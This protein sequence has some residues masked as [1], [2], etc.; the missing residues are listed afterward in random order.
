MDNLVKERLERMA[1][2]ARKIYTVN[3][4]DCD[5]VEVAELNRLA[6]LIS[7]DTGWSKETIAFKI[8]DMLKGENLKQSNWPLG[9]D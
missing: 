5:P 2:L 7:K 9:V 8:A 4:W 1:V 6:Q 3:C